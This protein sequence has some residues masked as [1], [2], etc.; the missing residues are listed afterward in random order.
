MVC[1]AEPLSTSRPLAKYAKRLLLW[2]AYPLGVVLAV[3]LLL[4]YPGYDDAYIT[5]RYARNLAEGKGFVFNKGERVLS[6]TTPL[7]ALIM[8]PF[9][10]LLKEEDQLVEAARMVGAVMLAVGAMGMWVLSRRLRLKY[11]WL[12][13]V[14]YPV[15]PLFLM[16]LTGEMPLYLALALWALV[17]AAYRRFAGAFL[18][19]ALLTLTRGDGFLLLGVLFTTYVLA[20]RRLPIKEAIMPAALLGAWAVFAVL[21]FGSPLPLTLTAKQAQ[22]SMA[23]S[24][25]FLPGLLGFAFQLVQKWT[26]IAFFAVALLGLWVLV[27]AKLA[28]PLLFWALLYIGAYTALG[29]SRYFW[30]YAPVFMV[31]LLL[32]IAGLQELERWLVKYLPR[33]PRVSTLLSSGVLLVVLAGSL[34]DATQIARANF[35]RRIAIYKAA[36]QWLRQH[37]PEEARVGMLE[38]G[39]IGL[40]SHQR[41]VDFAGLL[42]PEVAARLRGAASYDEVAVWAFGRYHPDYVVVVDNSLPHLETLLRE[43]SCEAAARFLGA[44]YTFQANLTIYRCGASERFT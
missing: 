2:V 14:L 25:P 12:A 37:V 18:L 41:I 39:V 30:Y 16:T 8:T 1:E 28:L 31:I 7:F 23:I 19:G 5:L 13:L 44:E 24:T 36:G 17:C 20:E 21:Y 6:T 22:G 27:W 29:V 38:I 10:L 4:A 11:S 32:F 34:A 26:Y 9:A 35:D 40:Y 3:R 42:Q 43:R 15:F 33:Q